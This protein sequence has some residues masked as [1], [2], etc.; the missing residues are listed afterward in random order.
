MK[1]LQKLKLAAGVLLIAMLAVSC[2]ENKVEQLGDTGKTYVTLV[3]TSSDGFF[4]KVAEPT[5][6]PQVFLLLDVRRNFAKESELSTSTT[7]ALTF[8]T[9]VLDA[10]NDEEGTNFIPIPFADYTTSPASTAGNLTVQFGPG[11]YVK[12]VYLTIPNAFN[13]DP[14]NEY[15]L[16]YV[17]SI[18]SGAG[19]LSKSSSDSLVV[20]VLPKNLY[21]GEYVVTAVNPMVDFSNATLLGNYPFTYNLVTTGANTVD[22]ID[23][24]EDYPLHQILSGANWSYYGSFAP[25]VEFKSDGSGEIVNMTNYWGN[26]AGNTRGCLLDDSQVWSWDPVTKNIRVKYYMTQPSVIVDAPHIRTSYDELWTYVGKR[27]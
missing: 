21:D 8:N 4:L 19:E 13:L 15:A 6:D 7:V 3:P 16:G 20:Q 14:A 27:D 11:E 18:T 26:P 10:W 12:E 17:M 25:Q 22:C 23:K 5:S 2:I 1:S 24:A 9:G